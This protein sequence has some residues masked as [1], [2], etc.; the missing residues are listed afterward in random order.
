MKFGSAALCPTLESARGLAH[1]LVRPPPHT[2]KPQTQRV[3]APRRGGRS[4]PG[5]GPAQV[6]VGEELGI[7]TAAVLSRMDEPLGRCV[8]AALEVLE[9]LQCMDGRGPKELRELVTLLGE[10]G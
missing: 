7:R 8:G 2:P 9:A 4:H 3:G 1:S 5:R 6:E 10:G